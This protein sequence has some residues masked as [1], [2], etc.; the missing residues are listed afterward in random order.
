MYSEFT[1]GDSKQI[2]TADSTTAALTENWG[3]TSSQAAAP[4]LRLRFDR[5]GFICYRIAWYG[6][7]LVQLWS[8]DRDRHWNHVVLKTLSNVVKRFQN[9]TVSLVVKMVKNG[10]IASIWKLSRILAQIG[11]LERHMA[12][13]VTLGKWLG[14]CIVFDAVLRPWN[15]VDLKLRSCKCSLSLSKAKNK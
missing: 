3:S 7:A 1:I 5:C 10:E 2:A 11:R 15:R 13:S 8:T 14:N 9:D 6:Y 12:C 4:D